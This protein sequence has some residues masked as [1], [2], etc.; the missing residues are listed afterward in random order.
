[1]IKPR[2]IYLLS[3]CGHYEIKARLVSEQDCRTNDYWGTTKRY[4]GAFWT[5]EMKKDHAPVKDIN[6]FHYGRYGEKALCQ[7]GVKLNKNTIL[8]G[9]SL[10]GLFTKALREVDCD[11]IRKQWHKEY[12][13][14]RQK[15]G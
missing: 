11:K 9:A 7:G 15:F 5:I 14:A 13:A 8:F 4:S 1:M 12:A 6:G 10:T 3:D 2:Y